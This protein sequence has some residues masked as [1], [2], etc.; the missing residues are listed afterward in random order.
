M[1]FVGVSDKNDD[2]SNSCSADGL[3]LDVTEFVV[4]LR[5]VGMTIP[6]SITAFTSVL[7]APFYF[8]PKRLVM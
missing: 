4:E 8:V 7:T 1:M 2:N 3:L 5:G 6:L